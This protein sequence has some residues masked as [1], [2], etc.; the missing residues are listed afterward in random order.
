MARETLRGDDAVFPFPF[1]LPVPLLDDTADLRKINT[2]F[3]VD[4]LD[5]DGDVDSG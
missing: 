5:A 2:R 1:P 3:D 4:R